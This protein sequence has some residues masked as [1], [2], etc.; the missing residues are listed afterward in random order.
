MKLC[1]LIRGKSSEMGGRERQQVH[2]R[3]RV[4]VTLRVK[5][6]IRPS[7]LVNNTISSQF[8]CLFSPNRRIED[9]HEKI[10]ETFSLCSTG[11][12]PPF[13]GISAVTTTNLHLAQEATLLPSHCL[14]SWSRP[15]P[16]SFFLLSS[17]RHSHPSF[18]MLSYQKNDDSFIS[19]FTKILK[20]K[21]RTLREWVRNRPI[22]STI[23]LSLTGIPTLC[24]GQI[25]RETVG[26][27]HNAKLY[28]A[29]NEKVTLVFSWFLWRNFHGCND[30]TSWRFFWWTRHNVPDAD[31]SISIVCSPLMKSLFKLMV[32]QM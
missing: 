8:C 24:T 26:S 20:R 9:F 19:F 11:G 6:R 2:S 25:S 28:I 5:G 30:A 14:K 32:A 4:I 18:K 7:S 13:S 12:S 21:V 27:N 31:A 1:P 3:C 10:P 23:D 17:P 22:L 29:P 15:L 16:A